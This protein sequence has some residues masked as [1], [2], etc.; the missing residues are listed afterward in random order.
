M[1]EVEELSRSHHVAIIS[2]EG[3][4]ARSAAD[5]VKA[6]IEKLEGVSKVKVCVK[7]DF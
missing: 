5:L 4:R 1:T 6:E 2:A 3:L 7:I